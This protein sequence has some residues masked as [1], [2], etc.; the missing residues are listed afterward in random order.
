MY[1]YRYRYTMVW[2]GVVYTSVTSVYHS[3]PDHGITYLF[4]DR[5]ARANTDIRLAVELVM[6]IISFQTLC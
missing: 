1:K 4:H 5:R 2:T 3:S 6:D